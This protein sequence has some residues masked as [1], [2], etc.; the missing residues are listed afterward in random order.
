[1]SDR[2]PH[3]LKNCST[4]TKNIFDRT[5]QKYW[6]RPYKMQN[7]EVYLIWQ[8][9]LNINNVQSSLSIFE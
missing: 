2:T 7:G 4:E 1:M 3:G 8:Q 5:V 9:Y 6:C